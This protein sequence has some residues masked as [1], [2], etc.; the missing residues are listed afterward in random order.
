MPLFRDI[1][2][3]LLVGASYAA[4]HLLVVTV[5]ILLQFEEV[6]GPRLHT[7][8]RDRLPFAQPRLQHYWSQIQLL[9]ASL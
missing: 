6:Y 2:R 9:L 5:K 7:T 8:N 4:A 3:I 1:A